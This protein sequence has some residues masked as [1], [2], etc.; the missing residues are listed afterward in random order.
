MLYIEK[1][2]LFYWLLGIIF[3]NIVRQ[4][5]HHSNSSQYNFMVVMNRYEN[6]KGE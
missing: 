3:Y 1:V 6:E 2:T 5:F 4:S